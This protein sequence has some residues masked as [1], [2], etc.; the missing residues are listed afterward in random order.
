MRIGPCRWRCRRA[1]GF[2]VGVM[3]KV[4]LVAGYLVVMI[5]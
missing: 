5:D 1:L 4:P 2:V 3:D